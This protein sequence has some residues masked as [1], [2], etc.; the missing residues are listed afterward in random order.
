MV[1]PALPDSLMM[2]RVSNTGVTGVSQQLGWRGRLG[3]ANATSGSTVAF[4]ASLQ[5]GALA[6]IGLDTPPRAAHPAFMDCPP[7]VRGRCGRGFDL[8]IRASRT[9]CSAERIA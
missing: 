3:V 1:R 4:G 2:I 7:A 5:H 9:V 8:V 6:C